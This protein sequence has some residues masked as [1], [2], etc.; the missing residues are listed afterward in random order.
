MSRIGPPRPSPQV[1]L[2]DDAPLR[3]VHFRLWQISLAAVVVAVTC[4]SYT[5]HF[6]L[7]LSATFLA[8]HILVAI[9]AVGLD[10]PPVR[11]RE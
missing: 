5:L 9:L 11:E 1:N 6:A 10:L 7:G 2:D 8:K 3:R 4:W